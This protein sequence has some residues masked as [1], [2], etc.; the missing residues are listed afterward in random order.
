MVSQLCE[1]PAVGR[2]KI[3]FCFYVKYMGNRVGMRISGHPPALASAGIPL[4]KVVCLQCQPKITIMFYTDSLVILYQMSS[5][6][7]GPTDQ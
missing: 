3:A 6:T 4:V 2:R 7:H 5:S 1:V